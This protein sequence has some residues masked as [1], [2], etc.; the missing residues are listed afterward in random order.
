MKDL[1]SLGSTTAKNGFINEIFVI[2]SFNN[3]QTN[4]MA[5]EWLKDMSYTIEEIESVNA[6][7]IKGSFK[8]DVQVQISI[9]IKL[10]KLSDIQN[11][12]V[13]LASNSSGFNQIDKRWVDKYQEL[14]EIPEDITKLLKYY[15]GE[16][17]PYTNTVRD[18]RR[19]FLDEMNKNEQ[20]SL[21]N[22]L[23]NNQS[24]IVSDILKG[25]GKFAAEWMLVILKS[26]PDNIKWIIKPMN[27]C[28][29]YF[30][31]GEVTITKQGNIKIG[32]ISIQR[33]GGDAGRKTAQMLQFKINPCLL[34]Q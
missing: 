15:T 11:I 18:K 1:A 22:F 14:W 29:N 28:L 2:D 21:I 17:P 34:F 27:F 32:N 13:K 5:Q 16:I 10:K 33:K 26:Q 20:L 12:Q 7:K 30:G 3:W 23:K 9:Y 24:L 8:A 25:R 6:I 19:M 4:T 31:N